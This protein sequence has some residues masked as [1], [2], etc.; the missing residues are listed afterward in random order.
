MPHTVQLVSECKSLTHYQLLTSEC[1]LGVHRLGICGAY[2]YLW[3][4]AIPYI[5]HYAIRQ[6]LVALEGETSLV[7]RLVKVPT[8]ELDTWDEQH[9]V[10]GQKIVTEISVSGESKSASLSEK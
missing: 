2:Y 7:H 10:L 8:A 6:E 1:L 3:I 5:G 4:Y 9:D